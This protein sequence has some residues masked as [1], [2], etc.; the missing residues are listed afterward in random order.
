VSRDNKLNPETIFLAIV[1][2]DTASTAVPRDRLHQEPVCAQ[3]GQSS[4]D[5][6]DDILALEIVAKMC[7]S[8]ELHIG[9]SPESALTIN[10]RCDRRV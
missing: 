4:L 8:D 10:E 2:A 1:T 7:N 6:E 5:V 9:M 3:T